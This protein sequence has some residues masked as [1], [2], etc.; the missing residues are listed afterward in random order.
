MA[1]KWL[2]RAVSNTDL[3]AA[4]ERPPFFT[5][6]SRRLSWHMVLLAVLKS[7]LLVNNLLV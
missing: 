7:V 4:V 6:F 2:V 5:F 1:V 3:R